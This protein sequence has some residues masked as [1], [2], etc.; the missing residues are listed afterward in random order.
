MV[1]IPTLKKET[2]IKVSLIVSIFFIAIISLFYCFQKSGFFLDELYSFG[3]SNGEY[4]PFLYDIKGSICNNIFRGEDFLKYLT[5]SENDAFNYSSVY[6]NQTQD[7]HPPLYYFLLH[8]VSSVFQNSFSKW[9]G[10]AINIV[11]FIFTNILVFVVAKRLFGDYTI[12]ICGTILYGLNTLAISALLMVRM[13]MMLSFITVLLL[14]LL[15]RLK[16]KETV[17]NYFLFGVTIFIGLL[18]Q[19]FFVFYAFFLCVFYCVWLLKNRKYKTLFLFSVSALGG[20]M[21]SYIA[22]PSCIKHLF[23]TGT[24]SGSTTLQN[25]TNIGGYISRIVHFSGAVILRSVPAVIVAVVAIVICILNFSKLKKQYKKT[26]NFEPLIYLIPAICAFFVIAIIAPYTVSRYVYNLLPIFILFVCFCMNMAKHCLE[27][28]EPYKKRTIAAV[29]LVSIC[30]SLVVKPQ[31]TYTHYKEFNK[32]V[33]TFATQP[34]IYITEGKVS[35]ITADVEQLSKY[36]TVYA[37]SETTPKYYE[38]YV[39]GFKYN[40][41]V[42][43]FSGEFKTLEHKSMLDDFCNEF[44]MSNYKE[45]YKSDASTCYVLS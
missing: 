19:Y 28:S 7:V 10:L 5:V 44:G 6:Y 26:F 20:V 25:I 16:E 33:E 13:Y 42:I 41:I 34:C 12:C 8:T 35:S 18:T 22:F 21:L 40:N 31:Y 27:H 2:Q 17:L 24:V 15:I 11:F 38:E 32:Q 1:N 4:T 37:S 45:L 14:Y 30:L 36:E 23:G 29:L 9:L 39:R 3:L 43:Y